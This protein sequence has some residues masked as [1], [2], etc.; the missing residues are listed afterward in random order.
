MLG[1][2]IKGFPSFSHWNG[3]LC[4]TFKL[5]FVFSTYKPTNKGQN[6]SGKTHKNTNK[7][8]ILLFGT[9]ALT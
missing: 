1:I 2:A 7:N 5:R 8:F 4:P 9:V 6:G 3:A